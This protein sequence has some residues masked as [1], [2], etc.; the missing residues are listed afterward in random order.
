VIQGSCAPRAWISGCEPKGAEE[1]ALHL[2]Y[3]IDHLGSGGAQRQLV[4]LATALARQPDV[5]V[6]V[7]VY[8]D[9]DFFRSRL[10]AAGVPVVRIEKRAKF[11]PAFPARVA[12]WLAAN[13][14]DLVHAFLLN[15]A[16]WYGL[17]VQLL[18]ARRRPLFVAGERDT[19]FADHLLHGLAQRF[20]YRMSDAVTA[21]SAAAAGAIETRLGIPPSRIHYLPNGIDLAAWDRAAEDPCPFELEAGSFHLALVGRL[22]P[23]KDHALLLEALSRIGAERVAGWRVWCVGAETGGQSF[24]AAIQADIQRR[25]LGA[26]VR[27]VPPTKGIAA[28]FRRLDGL[29]LPSRHEG[30]PNVL[31]EA[32]A[33]RLPSIAT[34]VGD[35]GSMLEDG[36]T[37]FMLEPR[38]ADGLAR[39]LVRLHAMSAAERAAMGK[40]ARAVVEARY[41]M[42]QVAEQHLELYRCLLQS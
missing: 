41:R 5:R 31:L 36:A 3:A 12:R 40:R 9:V 16:L 37:G 13:A 29:V 24:A 33:S 32:M 38:D 30:F 1:T 17:G 39:A 42:E 21:N 11:D 2:V 26:V 35:V 28:L 14:P 22:E 25:G 15:P 6:S 23:Q 19:K 34:R 18:P 20:V 4:E 8:R 10:D 7:L 27:C